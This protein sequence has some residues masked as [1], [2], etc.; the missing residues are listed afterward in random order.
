MIVC[1][2]VD[3]RATEVVAACVGFHDWT[4]AAPA[5]ESVTRTA[6]APPAYESGA[7]YR[8]EL[9]YLVAALAALA[10]APRMVVVDGYVWLAPGRPGLGAHL[11][12]ALG[13]SV[14][15]VGVA[16]RNFEGASTAIA[17]LRGTSRQPLFVTTAST[18]VAAAA[19]AVRAMHGA[20]R[21]PTLLKRVDRL[22]RDA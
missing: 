11:H 2:D 14:E 9:P 5:A 7:F 18:D 1:V 4:D 20:H 21:I 15:V 16:K 19:A 22:A 10:A 12:A 6:G 8:R 13:G 17:V 3:Y